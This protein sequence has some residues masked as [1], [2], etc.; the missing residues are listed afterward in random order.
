MMKILDLINKTTIINLVLLA[1]VFWVLCPDFTIP[2]SDYDA[3]QFYQYKS[4]CIRAAIGFVVLVVL[5]FFVEK[6]Q[7]LTVVVY[8]IA[9][10]GAMEAALS[11]LQLMGVAQ[12]HHAVFR[13]TG[14][15]YNPGPLGGYLAACDAVTIA[16]FIK[17][18][19][20]KSD[21][22]PFQKYFLGTAILLIS[23]VLPATFSRTAWI[24]LIVALIYIALTCDDVRSYI[25]KNKHRVLMV[26][27]MA[28]VLI[29]AVFVKKSVSASGRFLIWK[30]S[31]I[32]I[33]EKPLTGH[34]NFDVAYRDASETYFSQKNWSDAEFRAVD[35]V[36]NS[37][38]EYLFLAIKYG[39][40]AAMLLIALLVLA[41]W[42][43]HKKGNFE[44]AAGTIAVAVFAMASYPLHLADFVALLFFCL[45]AGLLSEKKKLIFPFM[46]VL[47]A[48][49]SVYGIK[50]FNTEI[51][52]IE[53]LGKPDAYYRN[54]AYSIAAFFYDELY[55]QL[56]DNK[57]YMYNL[58]Y[59]HYM[60][61]EYDM[62]KKYFTECV[63]ICGNSNVFKFLGKI[64]VSQND[65]AN[66]EKYLLRAINI[67]PN[68][69]EPYNLLLELYSN[70]NYRN[71][72]KLN[73]L[74]QFVATH[75]FKK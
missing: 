59:S 13:L 15:F 37:F 70:D 42:V 74:K 58:A 68:R 66:A 32:A 29:A 9:L 43:A 2:S 60:N 26:C 62:A 5:S 33:F 16:Y 22:E 6:Q 28:I 52:K 72:A 10:S 51:K 11:L 1:T 25:H 48:I 41:V 71:D 7:I 65:Y 36:D 50:H 21:S 24:A 54:E 64:C 27:L 8:A 49:I 53:L 14:T 12:S 44:F 40:P 3:Y 38:N 75:R 23:V 63:D 56:S 55:Q 39:I 34:G 73:E 18:Q 47:V 17:H 4:L 57:I 69:I 20:Y 35:Y 31:A 61:G 30:I 67:L 19:L 46:S 45:M